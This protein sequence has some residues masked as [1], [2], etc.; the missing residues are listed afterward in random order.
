MIRNI[1]FDVNGVLLG[2]HHFRYMFEKR[3]FPLDWKLFYEIMSSKEAEE[4]NIGLYASKKEIAEA[5]L[6]DHPEKRK[7]AL[8]LFD[9]TWTDYFYEV[10]EMT[11]FLEKLKPHF[12]IYL[13]SNVDKQEMAMIMGMPFYMQVDGAFF[14]CAEGVAKPE[15]TCYEAFLKKYGLK[16]EECLF[17]DDSKKNILAAKKLGFKTFLHERRKETEVFLTSLI[18]RQKVNNEESRS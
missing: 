4:G 16:A 18:H 17:L 6:K 12:R 14:S 11:A 5:Y 8:K 3:V 1:V 15:E 9:D 7:R 13:L 2:H 10:K